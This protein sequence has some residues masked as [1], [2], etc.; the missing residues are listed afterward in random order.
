MVAPAL[1]QLPGELK[2]VLR[3]PPGIARTRTQPSQVLAKGDFRNYIHSQRG[4]QILVAVGCVQ[5]HRQTIKVLG[6]PQKLLR[7]EGVAVGEMHALRPEERDRVLAGHELEGLLRGVQ[8][9]LL[10]DKL[11][12]GVGPVSQIG[13]EGSAPDFSNGV[14]V[15]LPKADMGQIREII[16][17]PREQSCDESIRPWVLGTGYPLARQRN[18]RV[19]VDV[20]G[21]P[22]LAPGKIERQALVGDRSADCAAVLIAAPRPQVSYREEVAR[23]EAAIL[24][25]LIQGA[26]KVT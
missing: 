17:I 20:T 11:V 14:G 1:A 8:E 4:K 3:S 9:P 18:L 15:Q 12:R 24:V 16:G 13:G 5:Q 23:I 2:P 19:S 6:E 21:I 7:R 25:R 26:A 10:Q 22:G